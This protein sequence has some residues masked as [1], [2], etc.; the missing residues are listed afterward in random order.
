MPLF[1]GTQVEAT[2][3]HEMFKERKK[4]SPENCKILPLFAIFLIPAK[5]DYCHSNMRKTLILSIDVAG[6]QPPANSISIAF[7]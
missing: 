1:K 7:Y 3:S 4:Y 5:P 6:F 2:T